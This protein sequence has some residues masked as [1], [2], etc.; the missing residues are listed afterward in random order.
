MQSVVVRQ[1]R[2]QI[3]QASM[4]GAGILKVQLAEHK[5][6]KGFDQGS[7]HINGL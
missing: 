4:K 2:V 5:A 3:I 6:A 7:M 1:I